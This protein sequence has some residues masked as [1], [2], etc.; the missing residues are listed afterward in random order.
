MDDCTPVSRVTLEGMAKLTGRCLPARLREFHRIDLVY[1]GLEGSTKKIHMQVGFVRN[2]Y[3]SFGLAAVVS[4]DN[5][6]PTV[7]AC[8][9]PPPTLPPTP[10]QKPNSLFENAPCITLARILDVP[11]RRNIRE[12]ISET[13]W[14][15]S[16][17]QR[18]S[19][20]RLILHR[21]IFFD[22]AS[23]FQFRHFLPPHSVI[24]RFPRFSFGRELFLPC[25]WNL[26]LAFT[27]HCYLQRSVGSIA[28]RYKWWLLRW[29]HLWI[30]G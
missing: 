7:L 26:L 4:K 9:L 17:F 20:P 14:Q 10:P 5:G 2:I 24:L 3:S 12:E 6:S 11:V 30:L 25:L 16:A 18:W 21:D 8:E 13:D 19:N 22:C 29:R 23:H 1:F 15:S 27:A 28:Y